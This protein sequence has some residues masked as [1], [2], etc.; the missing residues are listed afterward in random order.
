MEKLMNDLSK[1]VDDVISE[2][3]DASDTFRNYLKN[4]IATLVNEEQGNLFDDVPQ[5]STH[6]YLVT[7]TG[8]GFDELEEAKIIADRHYKDKTTVIDTKTKQV[9]YVGV[10]TEKKKGK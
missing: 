9:V 5:D 7:P 4:K 6:R 8:L 2:N 10:N 1:F 3:E